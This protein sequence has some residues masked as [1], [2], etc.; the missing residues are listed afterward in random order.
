VDATASTVATAAP[1]VT[2]SFSTV[3]LV[4]I[5]CLC[6]LCCCFCCCSDER[7]AAGRNRRCKC[8]SLEG[9]CLCV[10]MGALVVLC[11]TEPSNATCTNIVPFIMVL[12]VTMLVSSL[13]RWFFSS[14]TDEA[15]DTEMRGH[16]EAQRDRERQGRP[17]SSKG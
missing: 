4:C 1:E 2:P 10:A 9:L 3:I 15:P 16:V 14:H 7:E 6:V 13:A 8:N 17:P 12:V 11:W 5:P